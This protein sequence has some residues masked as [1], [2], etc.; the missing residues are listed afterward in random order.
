M[1]SIVDFQIILLIGLFTN[2][3]LGLAFITGLAISIGIPCTVSG[4]G[5]VL[6]ATAIGVAIY[7]FQNLKKKQK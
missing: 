2:G 4:V 1:H 3:V 5:V 6:V 7:K